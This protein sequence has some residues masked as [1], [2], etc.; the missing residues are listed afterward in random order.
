[1]LHTPPSVEVQPGPVSQL[2]PGH[3]AGVTHELLPPHV[4]L[5][6]H[7]EPQAT[8]PAQLLFPV[9]MTLQGPEPHVTGPPHAPTPLHATVQLVA[10]EQS[11]RLQSSLLSHSTVQAIPA[12]HAI[13]WARHLVP[14][15]SIVQLA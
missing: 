13:G 11:T 4:T 1:V 7:D 6:R 5:Q 2:A 10:C 12:G 8:P 9:Q 15:Q 14:A 3:V